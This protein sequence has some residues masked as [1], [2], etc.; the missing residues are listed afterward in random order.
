MCKI[1]LPF[2]SYN[3]NRI[4][5]SK[6]P[7]VSV[8]EAI[9]I[10][11]SLERHVTHPMAE[12]IC[13]FASEKGIKHA[14]ITH[15]QS[16][17]GFGLQ[18]H[19]DGKEVKIGNAEFINPSISLEKQS[20]MLTYLL[21]GEELFIFRFL[22]T[23]R[24]GTAEVLKDL[25]KKHMELVMLTGDHDESAQSVASAVGMDSVYANLRPEHK[26]ETVSK[27]SSEKPLAMVG[28]GINDA[29]ALTRASVGISMGEIGSATAIDASDIVLLKDD[30]SLITWLH[31]KAHQTM[32]IVRENLTLA[33]G[34]I[35]LATTP[36]LLGLIP[37]WLAVIL[38]EGGT[39]LVGLNSLR[40][41]KK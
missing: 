27:L 15:F 30:L 31:K 3:T 20:E 10:A 40:L 14:P 5:F 23:I 17:A 26:L 12:A 4:I 16:V 1:F 38:H 33:L 34:V 41:L 8:D 29:P 32:R 39:V 37:L 22:D 21:I 11:A 25:K 13:I 28:D 24:E 9:G 18:G 19:V 7:K 36:A 2:N 35:F 6:E